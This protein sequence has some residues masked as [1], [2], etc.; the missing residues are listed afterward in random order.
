MPSD[1]KRPRIKDPAALKRFRLMHIG[2]IC[3]GCGLV[4]G[5]DPHHV[6][7]RSQ[8]GDDV[9]ENLLWLLVPPL[10]RPSARSD[11]TLLPLF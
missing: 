9:P 6:K 3:E 7:Y 8:G 1:F 5:V 11:L 4:P 10:S 2:E